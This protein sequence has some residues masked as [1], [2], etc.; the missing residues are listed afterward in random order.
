M[1]ERHPEKV[2]G[3]KC[4]P[5]NRRTHDS[6]LSL[7]VEKLKIQQYQQLIEEVR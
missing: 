7:S 4:H 5:Y 6:F 3:Q 1:Q 2:M